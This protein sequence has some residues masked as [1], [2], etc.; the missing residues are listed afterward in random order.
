MTSRPVRPT[1][2][3]AAPW[4][5]VRGSADDRPSASQGLDDVVVP[6][7]LPVP[8]RL[9]LAPTTTDTA[10]LRGGWWP[11]SYDLLAELPGLVLALCARYG[12]IR[13]LGLHTGDWHRPFR[14]LVMDAGLVNISWSDVL[15]PALMIATTGVHHRFG[16]L[17]VAPH[18]DV[19]TAK[20]AMNM[21]A[22]PA[23]T[24]HARDILAAV[25]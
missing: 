4:P 11:H 17:V 22:D 7:T 9:F 14:Q 6:A 2:S 1:P 13:E 3:S 15:D 19:T 24:R 25:V 23:N 21:A 8:P 16:L 18:T 12:S 5:T 20:M 10:V